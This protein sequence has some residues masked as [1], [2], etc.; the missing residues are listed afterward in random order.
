MALTNTDIANILF[1]A[2]VGKSSTNNAR[3]FFEEP[4]DGRPIIFPEQVWNKAED[5]PATAPTLSHEGEDGVVKY[6]EDVSLTAV[7]GVS[8]SFFSDD[9]IDAIPFNFGDGS[10]NYSVKDDSDN[11]IAFG[12]GD[13]IVDPNTGTLTFYGSVPANMPPKISFYKYIGDKGVG[14]GDGG[15][16]LRY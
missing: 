6:F 11:P 9:L 7:P 1:K 16:D 2:S 15:A 14:S 3:E 5:I 10:Y 8:N 12:Q 13:W 4:R